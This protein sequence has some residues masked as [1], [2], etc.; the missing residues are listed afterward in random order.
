MR[1]KIKRAP[2]GALFWFGLCGPLRWRRAHRLSDDLNR[3]T[4][5]AVCFFSVTRQAKSTERIRWSAAVAEHP[6]ADLPRVSDCLVPLHRIDVLWGHLHL[7]VLHELWT[8]ALNSG[9][10]EE[11]GVL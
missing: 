11:Q 10:C 7:S 5:I 4:P 9:R 6:C 1:S 3:L 8:A 2:S